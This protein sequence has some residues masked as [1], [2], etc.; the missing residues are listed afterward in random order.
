MKHLLW[1]IQ[2]RTIEFDSN[3]LLHHFILT[4]GVDEM[5]VAILLT[6]EQIDENILFATLILDETGCDHRILDSSLLASVCL[7]QIDEV[8]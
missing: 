4:E 3:W 6:M 2:P 7:V 8:V 5:V 1:E